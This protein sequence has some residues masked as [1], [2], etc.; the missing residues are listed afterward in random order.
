M[1]NRTFV[2]KV[3]ERLHPNTYAGRLE[4]S[5]TIFDLLLA[6]RRNRISHDLFGV[7]TFRRDLSPKAQI[8]AA[9]AD[10]ARLFGLL[11]YR[12]EIVL[13]LLIHGMEAD[14]RPHTATLVADRSGFRGVM[15]QS[16]HLVDPVTAASYRTISMWGPVK[17]TRRGE[18]ASR[19]LQTA[20]Q[21]I[22]VEG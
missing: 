9:R 3:R 8:E 1:D 16:V 6:R 10:V 7:L 20:I 12:S 14:W 21:P 15:I 17:Y 13:H 19:E 11:C 22:F 18:T 4:T 2:L 5:G